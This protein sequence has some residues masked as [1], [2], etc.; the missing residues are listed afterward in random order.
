VVR[1][2]HRKLLWTY[3]PRLSPELRFHI[4]LRTAL[5]VNCALCH[6]LAIAVITRWP[7][8]QKLL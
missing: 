5:L 6:L 1:D 7:A 8:F 2:R 3:S 4:V